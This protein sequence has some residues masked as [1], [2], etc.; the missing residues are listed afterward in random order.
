MGLLVK[1][2]ED[3]I[4]QKKSS[5]G[6][7]VVR[8][9]FHM[10]LECTEEGRNKLSTSLS[11]KDKMQS[12]EE[13]MLAYVGVPVEF[14]YNHYFAP[15]VYTRE[16]FLPA[17][18]IVTGHIHRHSGTNIIPSGHVRV[19]TDEGSFDIHGP[20]TF[21][22]GPGVKKCLHVVTDTVWITTHPWDGKTTDLD[23][24]IKQF[25]YASYEDVAKEYLT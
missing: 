17:N 11:H 9:T 24:L 10:A 6:F 2:Q 5:K 1:K 23:E 7:E 13:K 21:I 20:H 12:L 8:D 15:G 18:S 4:S 14:E 22:S 3:L 19:I 25:C 16:M